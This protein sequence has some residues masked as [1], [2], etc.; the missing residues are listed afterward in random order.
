M[1]LDLQ[2]NLRRL[3]GI[4]KLSSGFHASI[5]AHLES[6][7]VFNILM[8]VFLNRI[9]EPIFGTYVKDVVIGQRFFVL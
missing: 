1:S 5:C 8:I 7:Q 2:N 3:D 4:F 6:Y 9:P